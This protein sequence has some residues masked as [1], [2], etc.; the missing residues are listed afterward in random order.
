MKKFYAFLVCCLFFLPMYG[1]D[2]HFSQ[3]QASPLL[4]NA[5]NTGPTEHFEQ[6]HY[7]DY[8]V[9]LNYRNQ[10]SSFI[11]PFVTFSGFFD[12]VFSKELIKGGYL[13]AGL[14]L[15]SDKAGT[16]DFTTQS[17]LGSVAFHMKMGANDEH[18]ISVGLQGGLVQKGANYDNLRFGNQYESV[19]FSSDASNGESLTSNSINYGLF[20]GGLNWS[21]RLNSDLKVNAGLSMFNLNSPKESFYESSDNALNSRMMI[22]AGANYQLSDLISIMP[23]VLF[24]GQSKA[25]EFLIGSSMGYKIKDIPLMQVTGLFG[26]YYRSADA[27]VLTPGVE[28]NNYRF[29]VSY[30]VNVSSLRTATKMKGA[31]ELS[32]VYIFNDNPQLGIKKSL[33]CKRL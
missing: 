32:L 25:N 7:A 19:N 5:A 28:Y 9:G 14:V 31:L 13:G 29:G 18:L 6:N 10:W 21:Y 23:A 1:Q 8:R 26:L 12:K 3:F 22:S 2:I 33:P 27:I 15:Y 11:K 4:L 17:F 20:N 24:A 16:A 30:D